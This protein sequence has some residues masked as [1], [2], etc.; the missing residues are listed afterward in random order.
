MEDLSC[1]SLLWQK[2]VLEK[3]QLSNDEEEQRRL[4]TA[5]DSM[6]M[7]TAPQTSNAP[8]TADP[9][10]RDE[11]LELDKEEW[12]VEDCADLRTIHGY[13]GDTVSSAFLV[14]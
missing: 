8:T 14:L 3:L 13:L 12:D 6:S 10:R 11:E 9:L 1:R 7:L 2:G 5:S 4:S